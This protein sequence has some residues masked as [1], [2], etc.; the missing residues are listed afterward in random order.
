MGLARMV[1][2]KARI[3]VDTKN[4]YD[5]GSTGRKAFV[6]RAGDGSTKAFS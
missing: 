2:N 4:S 3:G 1:N 5:L 6:C